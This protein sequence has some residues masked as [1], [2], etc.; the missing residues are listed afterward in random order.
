MKPYA[1]PE[2]PPEG[3]F[4]L[5]FGRCAL[6]TQG[7][8]VNNPLLGE[9]MPENELWINTGAAKKLGLTDGG[10]ANVSRNGYS[11]QIKVKITDVIHPE[12]VFVIHGFGHQ[13]PVES[14]A[15]G[16][17]LADNKF[18]QGGL[19]LWDP[20]GGAVAYQEFFVEV[21]KA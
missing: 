13:L 8:T 7:H 21:A 9:Q 14:R 16:K 5:T 6:H 20:A 19:D 10:W 18:M 11:E 17:G 12:A 1:S 4:R 3:Q 2:H 15:F